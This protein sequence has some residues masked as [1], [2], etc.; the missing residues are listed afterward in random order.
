MRRHPH[1]YEVN[2]RVLVRRVS[3]LYH[4]KLSLSAIPEEE[5]QLLRN[6][7]FDLV[8]LM[9]V[10]QR[11]PGARQQALLHPT[12][13]Q[14]Y[15]QALPDWSDADIAG[16]PYAVY[17][18]RLD[19]E[20]G[21]PGELA[22]LKSRLNRQGLSLLLDFV[23]NHLALDHP[24]TL[25]HPRRFV[26]GSKAD[27]RR[28]PEW[29]FLARRVSSTD[30]M[31]YLAHGRDPNFPPWTDTV[32][33]N[34]RS[35]DLRQAL[36]NKLLQ[37]A[38]VADGVRCDMAMLALNDVF[39]KV[40][41][42]VVKDYSPPKMEFWAEAIEQVKRQ[43]PDFLSLAEV[44]WGLERKLQELGFDFTYDK[45]L[46]DR[47]RFSSPAEIRSHLVAND[48]Y[49]QRSAR[50]IEN[51]DE[52][53]AIVAFGRERSLAAT[54]V[55]ATVPGLRLFHD[56]QLEGRSIR[57]PIQLVRQPKE[58]DD[59]EITRFYN[60]L[61]AVCSAPA[62]HEGEWTLVEPG[63]A[64][65]G[66]ESHR[67]LLTWCWRYAEQVKLVVVD[68]SPNRAQG[69]LKWPMPLEKVGRVVLRD[70]LTGATYI[71]NADELRSRGLYV[72]LSPWQAHILDVVPDENPIS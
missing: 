11:S 52:L 42:E 44:Y 53:R 68:Y 24:W 64:W 1:M 59:A 14:E 65:E 63:Q 62:F 50:F 71:R 58:A 56:G 31:T 6:K 40:W 67:N 39:E 51:H 36:I 46:Y 12:L 20:L 41:G 70:E 43:R 38:E 61:L 48:L 25:T 13:R 3:E 18:Y 32:Q 45:S 22:Q 9:G 37:I 60:R 8:W 7:G 23:P 66:N 17:A 28:H 21:Q 55:L 10:W 26:R 54:V 34:F 19:P 33:V 30:R 4:R 16:S 5:W 15:D 47:L 57:L 72:D 29:F 49:Q 69:W 27:T 35:T 2:A